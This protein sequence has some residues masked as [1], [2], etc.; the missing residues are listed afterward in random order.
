[1]S[2]KK[3]V[4][5]IEDDEIFTNPQVENPYFNSPLKQDFF[6]HLI[7]ARNALIA[8]QKCLG[9]EES[10]KYI[11]NKANQPGANLSMCQLALCKKALT[12]AVMEINSCL[13]M[14][15]NTDGNVYIQCKECAEESG[16]KIEEVAFE[17][18]MGIMLDDIQNKLNLPEELAGML[19]GNPDAIDLLLGLMAD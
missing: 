19:F 12:S 5:K 1:M 11:R 14:N 9:T 10:I 4:K 2:D 17:V 8:A 6:D 16:K 18:S 15:S 13:V 3:H 7:T